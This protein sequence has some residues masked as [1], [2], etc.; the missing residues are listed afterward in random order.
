MA[1]SVPVQV[2]HGNYLPKFLATETGKT[3]RG[4]ASEARNR[5]GTLI[6]NGCHSTGAATNLFASLEAMVE[7]WPYLKLRKPSST[8]VI[9]RDTQ[10]YS[11]AASSRALSL[12]FLDDI[13]E[14][15]ALQDGVLLALELGLSKVIFESDALSIIQA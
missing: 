8:G 6:F 15:L 1:K 4:Y 3:N 5:A 9:I 10:G 2:Q 11:I 14:A 7:S 13:S 12:P